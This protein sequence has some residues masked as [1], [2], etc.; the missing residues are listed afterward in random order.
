MH[1][2]FYMLI[3]YGHMPPFL[4]AFLLSKLIFLCDR[5]A[6]S[7]SWTFHICYQNLGWICLIVTM[8]CNCTL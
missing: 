7:F 5:V 2:S 8:R 1:V 4:F 3:F 6:L